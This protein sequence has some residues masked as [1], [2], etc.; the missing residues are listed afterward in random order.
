M[1]ITRSK[2]KIDVFYL[3][4]KE[5]KEAYEDL[6]NNPSITILSRHYDKETETSY[7]GE[8]S[9]VIERPFVRVEYEE[10]FI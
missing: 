4:Q 6:L 9:V 5:E 10:C 7:E 3:N 2:K 8:A 1:F